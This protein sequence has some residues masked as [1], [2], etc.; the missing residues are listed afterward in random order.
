MKI[1]KEICSSCSG[2]G[3]LV[4]GGSLEFECKKCEKCDGKGF[5]EIKPDKI[6][7]YF[8]FPFSEKR[9][10][11][12]A[13]NNGKHSSTYVEPT[14]KHIGPYNIDETGNYLT[15]FCGK[16]GYS[17]TERCSDILNLWNKEYKK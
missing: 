17:W 9:C 6:E 4:V 5:L 16:C 3:F 8:F 15:K 10:I 7:E 14:I 12:P 2:K 1:K 13:C 11:C